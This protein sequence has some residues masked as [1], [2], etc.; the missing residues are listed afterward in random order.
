MSNEEIFQ[1]MKDLSG[2]VYLA[3]DEV[4]L[5]TSQKMTWAPIPVDLVELVM[6]KEEE[7]E[8]GMTQEDELS[9]HQDRRDA[10][11]LASRAKAERIT[12]RTAHAGLPLGVDDMQ[13]LRETELLQ[14]PGPRALLERGARATALRQ[15]APQLPTAQ[16]ER[17]EFLGDSGAGIRHWRNSSSASTWI[18]RRGT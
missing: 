15:R 10:V 6:A 3:P 18:C 5:E 9:G 11:K 17:L 1:T 12:W 7:F 13:E 4:T 8:L 16:N 14:L 2:E